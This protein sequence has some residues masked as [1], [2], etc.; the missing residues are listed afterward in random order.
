MQYRRTM[1]AGFLMMA[2]SGCGGYFEDSHEPIGSVSGGGQQAASGF[3]HKSSWQEMY[4]DYDRGRQLM[5]RQ[6]FYASPYV[7]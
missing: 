6:G 7:Q 4:Y 5:Q 3:A 1:I 2:L